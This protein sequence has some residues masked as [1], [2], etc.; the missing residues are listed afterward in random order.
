M[1]SKAQALNKVMDFYGYKKPFDINDS[2]VGKEITITDDFYQL[3]NRFL[4]ANNN[5]TISKSDKKYIGLYI[6]YIDMNKED[7]NENSWQEQIDT[8][9]MK[10]LKELSNGAKEYQEVEDVNPISLDTF[11]EDTIEDLLKELGLE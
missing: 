7:R 9:F 1:M 8:K 4:G 6:K 3:I 11:E 5:E 2:S 10:E